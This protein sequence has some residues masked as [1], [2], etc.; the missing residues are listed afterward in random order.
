MK[1]SLFIDRD[2]TIIREPVDEQIDSFEKFSFVPGIITSLSKIASETDFD[3][4]LV[5]N[6]DGLGTSSFPEETFWPVQNKMLEILEGEGIKFSSIFIDRSFPADKS[7]SRKPGTAMLT[8]YLAQGI[9]LKNSYVI[10]DRETDVQLAGNLGC[11]SIYLG[12]ENT[13]NA[14]FATSEWSEIYSYLKR[15]PR[16]ASVRRA[17]KETQ[18][19]IELNLD[20]TGKT[21]ISTGVGFF[22]HMLEQISRHGGFDLKIEAKGDLEIDPHH[23]IEDTGITLGETFLKAM[24]SKKGI[25]RYGFVLPMDDCL[26]QVAVDFGGRPWLVWDVCFNGNEVGSIPVEL[27]YHFFKSFSDNAKCNLNIKAE[28]DNNHHKIEGTFK[29]FAKAMKNALKQNGTYQLPTTKGTL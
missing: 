24:G 1:K 20:G 8:G 18:I 29:A 2:G 28:G 22:D 26:C 9:D 17:T 7:P 23:L 16:A 10:G 6:Q 4:V 25:E 3:L 11:N 21:S 27:F 5:S 15:K 12:K 19:A 14:T 13:Y